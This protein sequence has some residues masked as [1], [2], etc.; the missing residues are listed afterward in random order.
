MRVRVLG[1]GVAGL[2]CALA[3]RRR[4]GFDDVVVLERDSPE[5]AQA[6]A[7]TGSC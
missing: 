6:R 4:C 7:V 5:V 1:G 3:V 2:A